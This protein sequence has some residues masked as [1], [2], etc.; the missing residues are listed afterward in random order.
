MFISWG[1]N[2]SYYTDSD[3]TFKGEGYDFTLADAKASDR[4]SPFTWHRYFHPES[5][6]IPQYNLRVGYY[7]KKN[8]SWSFNVDHF[9]YVLDNGNRVKV[10][11]NV[12]PGVDTVTNLSGKYDGQEIVTDDNTFTH[13]NSNGMNYIRIGLERLISIIEVNCS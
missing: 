3:L 1:Y 2:R 7:Y 4:P 6:T 12:N 11:G 9:K 8:W 10:Y 13:E 5:I